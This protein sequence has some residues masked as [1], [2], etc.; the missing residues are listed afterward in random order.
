MKKKYL[1][2]SILLLGLGSLSAQSFIGKL[3]PNPVNKIERL[4]SI[5]TLK[6]LAVLSDFKKDADDA[7][8]GDGKFETIYSKEYGASILDPLPHDKKYFESHLKFVQNYFAKVSKGKLNI[9]YTVLD[10]ILTVSKTMRNYTPPLDSANNHTRL[11]NYAKEVWTLAEQHYS[12]L[13]FSKYDLFIVFHA[14][15]GKD[16]SL[17]GSIGNERDLPSVYLSE[18]SLQN[19]FGGDFMGFGKNS[20][21]ANTAIMPETES[22]ELGGF[23]GKV[24][25][26]L[27]TNGLLVA[28]VGSYLGLPDLYNT[29]TGRSAIGRFGLM[30]GQSMFTFKGIFP[31]EPSAWEK[32]FLG[33]IT[34][35]EI[36]VNDKKISIVNHLVATSSDTT[37]VKIPIN[38][39][40]YYLVEN[41]KRD[42]HKDGSIVTYISNG[43]T[44][45]KNF[46][47]DYKEFIYYNV[48]TLR[49][50][51]IDV[52][53][54]DWALPNGFRDYKIEKFSEVGLIIWHIDEK[55]ISDN[56]ESNTIN[57]DKYAR[58]IAV[59]EADGIR[60]IGEE[61]KTVFGELVIGEGSK[62]DT[63][64]KNNPADYYK[65]IFSA[66]TK[67]KALSNT[68][69]N[70]LVSLS[71]FSDISNKA[72][73]NIAFGSNDIELITNIALPIAGENIFWLSSATSGGNAYIFASNN[74]KI[75]TLEKDGTVVTELAISNFAKPAIYLINNEI[76]TIS[77]A[78]SKVQ[79]AQLIPKIVRTD[80]IELSDSRFSTS[81]VIY[82]TD[83]DS[84]KFIV[85]TTDG[86]LNKYSIDVVGKK[87][88]NLLQ[89]EQIFETAVTK[90]AVSGNDYVAVSKGKFWSTQLT[91]GLI[92]LDE[93]PM[94]LLLSQDA[95]GKL[96]SIVAMPNK[97]VTI[98]EDEITIHTKSSST[99]SKADNVEGA[100]L[101]DVMILADAKNDGENYLISNDGNNL[102]MV[103][104]AGVMASNFPFQDEFQTPLVASPLA[105][106]LNN[107]KSSDIIACT[108]DGNIIAVDGV[109]GEMLNGFPISNGG[110]TLATPVIFSE[111]GKTGLAIIT[112]E[113]KFL[114]WNISKYN[115]KKFWTEVNGN[116][117]NS[118]SVAK[119]SSNSKVTQFFP[120]AKAYN[121]PNPVYS[122][123][124][125]IR[126][127]VAEDSKAE[128]TIFDL[129]GDLVAKLNGNG[130]GGVTNN[131]IWNID[132][133]QSGVYF[134][135]LKVTGTSGKT[136]SK[137]I[138]IAVVK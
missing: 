33:W 21:I 104:L 38:A 119:A 92:S 50:V 66:D 116:S 70:S 133:I 51:V 14:G 101:N 91:N 47:K 117:S 6:I 19:I 29:K 107:D 59:V 90:V 44:Y 15:V 114:S 84:V 138:K 69:G 2:V 135:H 83:G 109:T 97:F 137:I 57:N 49:G 65:N 98:S 11:G 118:S 53:E 45:T 82:S 85:G 72:S 56:Y 12:N 124:T 103:N 131:I 88:L 34:P 30:D 71:N 106:D 1:L 32:M 121:W 64:Y 63:W 16:V 7:T 24:L 18:K 128:V 130:R 81:P 129:A 86:K 89:S 60:D 8:F 76:Y 22:R 41:R 79:V 80:S 125:N 123:V 54:F 17:P 31:P 105:V 23:N 120:Q 94:Q 62:E 126:Y 87:K 127:Y 40:E 37:V 52:D 9:S 110:K 25:I 20:T 58:G 35:T 73:F 48:D 10:E 122:G 111:G 99:L 75:Y 46:D 28:T 77:T 5:D 95:N 61:F 74:E 3:N 55:V 93:T 68:G 115:G 96:T 100:T 112:K 134:A 13:D 26:E 78:P 43:Q 67:P 132:N 36:S 27:T 4:A 102:V 136:D 42:A 108:A 39:T 113:N